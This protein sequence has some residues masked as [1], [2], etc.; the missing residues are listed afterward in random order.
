MR[1]MKFTDRLRWAIKFVLTGD[2]TW[3]ATPVV[4]TTTYRRVDHE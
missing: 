1:D 2:W 4:I 3:A